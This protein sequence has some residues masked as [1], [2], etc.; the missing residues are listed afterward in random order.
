MNNDGLQLE[1]LLAFLTEVDKD[2]PIALSQKI[3]LEELARKMYD[4]ADFAIQRSE[5]GELIGLV[6]GYATNS[7]GDIAFMNVAAIKKI[8]RGNG[9]AARLVRSFLK[10]AEQKSLKGVHL[11]CVKSNVA[12]MKTYRKCGFKD[13]VLPEEPRPEDAHL[14][15]WF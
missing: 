14:I 1:E 4:R 9:I 7:V 8:H 5:D 3:P 15:Y 12:A 13:Y 2:F 10:I 11:Y 6:G